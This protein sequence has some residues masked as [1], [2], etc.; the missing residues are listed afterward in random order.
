[1]TFIVT[2]FKFLRLSY[3]IA[4]IS[5]IKEIHGHHFNFIFIAIKIRDLKY[6]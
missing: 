5:V 1:M 4:D 2:E 3:Q 6:T